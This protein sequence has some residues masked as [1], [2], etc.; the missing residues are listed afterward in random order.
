MLFTLDP[1][2]LITK[3]RAKNRHPLP[4][5]KKEEEERGKK[6]REREAQQPMLQSKIRKRKLFA[7]KST[8]RERETKKGLELRKALRGSHA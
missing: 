7:I 5:K 6:K 8:E 1:L 3:E 4:K 2:Q